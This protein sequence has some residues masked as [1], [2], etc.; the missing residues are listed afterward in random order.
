MDSWDEQTRH[1]IRMGYNGLDL[2]V[3]VQV[4]E[5]NQVVFGTRNDKS[6]RFTYYDFVDLLELKRF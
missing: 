3:G 6:L 2:L 5:A 1:G 4:E